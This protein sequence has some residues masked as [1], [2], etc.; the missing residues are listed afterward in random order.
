MTSD[1]PDSTPPRRSSISD[2]MRQLID[3]IINLIRTQLEVT[4]AEVGDNIR[5]SAGSIAAVAVGGVFMMVAI[6]CLLV[7]VIAWLA[8]K[9]GLVAAV[10]VVAGVLGVAGG[11]LISG[12]V[13][14]LRRMDLA[15]KHAAANLKR[16]AA[17]LK[18]D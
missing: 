18:G 17:M 1:T 9:V 4:R 8:T 15:P 2:L 14:K 13:A 10:L 6:L 11:V 3:D 12:G 7:A 5:Q 16:S